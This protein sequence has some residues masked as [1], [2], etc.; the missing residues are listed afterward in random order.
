MKKIIIA[1]NID[2]DLAKKMMDLSKGKCTF[3]TCNEKPSIILYIKKNILQKPSIDNCI[4]V[5]NNHAHSCLEGIIPLNDIEDMI[6]LSQP[7]RNDGGLMSN[8]TLNTRD[9]Y[10]EKA[11][12]EIERSNT[13]RC[14]F[15]GPLPLHPDWY[16]DLSEKTTAYASMDR[17]VSNALQ[18][19]NK[20]VMIIFRNNAR[21]LS[22]VKGKIESEK[23]PDLIKYINDKF[24]EY[25]KPSYNNT[26]V[27]EDTGIFHI[28][29]IT[30]NVC[31]FATRESPDSPVNG[32]LLIK[33]KQTI[34]WEKMQFDKM[35]DII[36][37]SGNQKTKMRLF[38]KK[39]L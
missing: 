31:I 5:C 39:L 3:F 33:D 20:K 25:L 13:L 28:P 15:V 27:V 8:I 30:D 32:G 10:I 29:I 1:D 7:H 22:K 38:L 37:E 6:K 14:I 9:E 17:V 4:V 19:K 26:L 18:D 34:E 12:E 21:Y 36:A 23:I 35:V 24:S 11:I 2:E 16:F